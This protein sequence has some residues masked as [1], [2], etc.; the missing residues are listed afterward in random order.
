MIVRNL[1]GSPQS[2]TVTVEYPGEDGPAQ[3]ALPPLPLEAYTTKDIPLDL[4]LGSLPLPLP[5]CSIR[6]QY[7][8]T[9]GS[10]IGEVSSIEAK[11]DLVIDSRLA[12]ERD[13]WV[14]SGAHPWRLDEETESILFLTNMSE[15]S[16][17]IGFDMVAGGVHYYLTRLKL[18]PHE[19]RAIDLRKVRDEQKPDLKGNKVPAGATDGSVV[20]IRLD[21]VPVMGRLVVLQR[22]KNM[23]SSYDCYICD[24]PADYDRLYVVPYSWTLLPDESALYE[25]EAWF[26]E[27]CNQGEWPYNVEA[28]WD[29]RS[30]SVATIDATGIATGH[31]GGTATITATFGDFYY[32]YDPYAMECIRHPK[33]CVAY[34]TCKVFTFTVNISPSIVAPL[35]A[36]TPN[37]TRVTVQT[38]PYTPNET[39][40]LQ[41]VRVAST[42]GHQTNHPTI[43]PT[44][45][46]GT[47]NPASGTTNSQGKFQSTYTARMFGGEHRIKATI[48]GV[49]NQVPITLRA[50]VGGLSQLADGANFDL[51]GSTPNH[52]LPDNHYGTSTANTGLVAI[53]TQYAGEYPQSVLQ[54][55]DQSLPWG[56][57]F[58][59]GP[60]QN[61][62][63][64]VYW[65]PPHE[66][67][68]LGTDCDIDKTIVPPERH[69]T[70]KRIIQLNGATVP[71]ENSVH[72]HAR[73]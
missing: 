18:K 15:Q 2:V 30:P 38:N 21:H 68:R 4:V 71:E 31:T 67:H 62:P 63:T 33:V 32:S 60:T 48:H 40:T 66:S 47:F 3:A 58:D 11:G 56:G 69:A 64:C 10:V 42:G 55:N 54:Y 24:C 16:A 70:V 8:G 73:W 35:N 29:S 27:H 51:I 46:G 13:G 53:A 45:T 72:W 5:F 26:K 65:Q 7:S 36:G 22:H 19:T 28:S 37:T 9:P 6:I 59:I 23:A 52:I 20:W 50:L 43:F 57:L 41:D 34:G 44:G 49:T 25:A 61:C 17:R 1:A 14:G 39:V 12:N